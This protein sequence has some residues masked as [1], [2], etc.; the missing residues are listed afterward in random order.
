MLYGLVDGTLPASISGKTDCNTS[1]TPTAF[2]LSTS[3]IRPMSV[4]E[5]RK[6]RADP[7]F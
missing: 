5:N 7:R 2:F 4:F 3:L 1:L 6:F